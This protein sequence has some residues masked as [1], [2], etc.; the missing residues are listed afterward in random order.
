MQFAARQPVAGAESADLG[1]EL[2]LGPPQLAGLVRGIGQATEEFLDESRDR[3]AALRRLEA[4]SPIGFVV[5]RDCDVLHMFRYASVAVPCQGRNARCENIVQR[6]SA[7]TVAQ[8]HSFTDSQP[9][10][11][12]CPARGSRNCG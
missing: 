7:E 4:G 6:T 3:G 10:P 11:A 9:A 1:A 2:V 5:D 8:F 12:S